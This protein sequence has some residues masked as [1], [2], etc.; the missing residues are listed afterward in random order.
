VVIEGPMGGIW[1]W[2]I[3]GIGLAALY[4]QRERPE[5]LYSA[6]VLPEAPSVPLASRPYAFQTGT[7]S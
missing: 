2:S 6:D 4:I 5:V 3:M 1:F 7:V